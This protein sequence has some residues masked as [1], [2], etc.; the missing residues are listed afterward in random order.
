ME[1]S[2]AKAPSSVKTCSKC[3]SEG[4]FNKNRCEPDGLQKWCKVCQK[5]ASAKSY[6]ANP[7]KYLARTRAYQK[8]H[9]EQYK[10]YEATTKTRHPTLRLWQKAKQRAK[11]R[12]IPFN[13]EPLDIVIPETCPLLG[14][15]LQAGLGRVQPNSPTLDRK[16]PSL[17][18]V[19][20]NVW[21][22]SHRANVM[23]NDATVE[24]VELLAKNLRAHHTVLIIPANATEAEG[25]LVSMMTPNTCSK[26]RM[27]PMPPETS[28]AYSAT[29]LAS[30][31]G[32]A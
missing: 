20:G 30:V 7:K 28:A 22:I 14:M 27:P 1:T 25:T 15:R 11:A 3:G 26:G 13:L 6:A 2:L 21:V 9:P 17:G 5:N 8:A 10:Q 24:E 23:K 16:I 32:E 19:R 12:G 18:Y 29:E 31:D 4:P